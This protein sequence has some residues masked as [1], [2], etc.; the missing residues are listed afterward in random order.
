MSSDFHEMEWYADTLRAWHLAILRYAVRS[1]GCFSRH[2][3]PGPRM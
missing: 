2:F 3:G 1:R